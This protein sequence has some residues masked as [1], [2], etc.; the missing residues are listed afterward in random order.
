MKLTADIFI[1][2]SELI[3]LLERKGTSEGFWYVPGG[4]VEAGEDP[5]EAAV[6]EAHEETGL[7]IDDPEILRVWCYLLADGT[8]AYHA[9]YLAVSGAGAV[10]ISDEHSGYQWMDPAAYR[11]EY[12]PSA[13]DLND[14]VQA[15]FLPELRR[16][17][18]LLIGKL[19]SQ[20]DSTS[21]R[22]SL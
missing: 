18:D 21:P 5:A 4:Y 19:P 16:N 3:L 11:D 2:R 22:R 7:E 12:L 1:V 17:I 9:T 14:P 13:A 15:S 6:R 10:T 8:Y 20:R